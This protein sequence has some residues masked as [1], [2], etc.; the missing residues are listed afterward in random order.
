M[1]D[2]SLPGLTNYFGLRPSVANYIKPGKRPMSSMSP[3]IILNKNNDVRLVIGASGGSK[4]I[5]AVAQTAIQNLWINSN[6]KDCIDTKRLHHQLYPEY[7]EVEI[8]TE[9]LLR[10][11]LI[12][13]GHSLKCSQPSSVVQ[14]IAKIS[15]D[16]IQSN[17]DIRKGGVPKGE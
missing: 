7:V 5:S 1:D 8:G 13:K 6:I 10:T 17:C 4:I 12:N 14:G 16:I 15:D 2:F 9:K 3:T 11:S